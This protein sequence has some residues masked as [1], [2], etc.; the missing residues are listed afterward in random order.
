MQLKYKK[1]IFLPILFFI[2]SNFMA[3]KKVE[4]E[5]PPPAPPKLSISN[6]TMVEGDESTIFTFSVTSSEAATDAIKVDYKTEEITAAID[7][8]F[9]PNS[10]T[11][12]ISEGMKDATIEVEI[13]ADTLK[14]PDEQFKIVLSNPVNAT[15]IQNEGI[16]T[17]RNDDTYVE[18][19]EDGYITP[20]SYTGYDLVW[21]D[22]FNG[23]SLNTD[24]W[25][26][27][28]GG[29]GW[30]NNE[31][32][33][34][35]NRED[36][37]YLTDGNLVIEAKQESF[38]G[39]NFTSARLITQDKKIFQHGRIDIRAIL[40]E[41]QGIWPA[42]WMLGNNFSEIGWPA[43]G[44][45]DIMELVGHEPSTTHGTIHWGPQ[46]QTYSH[47]TGGDYHLNSGK[48]SDEFHVFSLVWENNSIIW[49]VDDNEFFRIT[50]QNVN[51]NYPFNREF[52]F[53]F[54]IAVGGNWPGAPDASTVFPQRMYVDYIRVFQK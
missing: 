50:N 46:G 24:D 18:V 42:L 52:F 5:A 20:E 3:C 9:I 22:E 16:G 12:T 11:L 6:V 53:I 35:T 36:N 25:T 31:L 4:D 43:C 32:Q 23:T 7:N 15:L 29:H 54:N 26:H 17:I 45:I 48:F 28:M 44:E 34:Y 10:G 40:P 8:D 47:Y 21:R 19:A 37:A 1:I 49:Y 2:A 38:G 41:G 27:E 39:R 33:Y 14:E 51:G 13:V 30:G